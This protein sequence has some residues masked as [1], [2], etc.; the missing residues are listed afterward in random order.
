MQGDMPDG[1]FSE[2]ELARLEAER[3]IEIHRPGAP[4]YDEAGRAMAEQMRQHNAEMLAA[5]PDALTSDRML[6]QAAL[7]AEL[8]PERVG[9]TFA[10]WCRGYGWARSD[11]A[12]WLGVTTSQLAALALERRPLPGNLL[13]AG[14]PL[15]LARRFCA[16]SDRLRA[17][18]SGGE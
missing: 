13:H 15:A 2:A 12:D 11:L 3:T 17:V 7:T 16:D 14:E 5:E 10:A 8:D 4:G 6:R 9:Y 1:S 18:L